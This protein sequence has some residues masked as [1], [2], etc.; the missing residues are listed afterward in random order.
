MLVIE[1]YPSLDN[2]CQEN[3][4]NDFITST[5]SPLTNFVRNV[6]LGNNQYNLAYEDKNLPTQ[7]DAFA[8]TVFPAGLNFNSNSAANI[9]YDN[10]YLI[11]ASDL[12]VIMTTA[13]EYVHV[14]LAY[15]YSNGTL[16]QNYPDYN[17]LNNAFISFQNNSNPTTAELLAEEM[18]NVY[19]DFLDWITESVFQYATDNNI[20]GATEEYCNKLVIGSHQ[21]TDAFQNLNGTNQSEYSIIAT[22]EEAG[23][24]QANG[25]N[26]E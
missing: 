20:E 12:S 21:Y 10:N 13:H 17:N 16:L 4:I 5:D 6:F 7:L 2:I 18:H 9:Q 25:T 14:Y 19:D 11:N 22:N 15:L 26:C 3:K 1:F 24:E 23:N 8:N